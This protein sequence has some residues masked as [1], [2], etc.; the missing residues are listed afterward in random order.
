MSDEVILSAKE[1]GLLE[2]VFFF[3]RLERK[4]LIVYS[5]NRWYLT[6]AGETF[7][8][9]ALARERAMVVAGVTR[10]ADDT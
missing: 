8:R 2:N 1:H 10:L 9:D 3:E 4:G 7:V 6:P 5:A